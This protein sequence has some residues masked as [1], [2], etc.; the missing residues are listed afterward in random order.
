MVCLCGR[1]IYRNMKKLVT[2]SPQSRT[3][4][5]LSWKSFSAEDLFH[6]I[7]QYSTFYS[8]MESLQRAELSSS[9]DLLR[10]RFTGFLGDVI[11]T[12]GREI[13]DADTLTSEGVLLKPDPFLARYRM[14]SP[15]VDGLIRNQVI[16]NIFPDAP[17]SPPPRQNTGHVDV[18]G[19]LTESLKFFDKALILNASF[20]SYKKSKVKI[21][22]SH[23]FDVPRESVYDTELIRILANWLRKLSWSVVG[24]WHLENNLRKRKYS[25]IVLKKDSHTI[26]LELLATG[27]PSIVESHIRKTP[28]YAELLSADEAW[29]VH[30]TRQEDYDPMWLSDVNVNVVH[31]AHDPGFTNVVMSTRWTDC[32]GEVHQEVGKRVL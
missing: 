21:S 29:V 32:A 18:L 15:L 31:F 25:D 2:D 24:Q 22:T 13:R 19:L 4:S 27:E 26:V 30:F 17:S 10:S 3:I 20:C 7:S 16:P 11:L 28:E 9:V 6:E 23:G 5:Y 8:M 12:D 14:A 1:A